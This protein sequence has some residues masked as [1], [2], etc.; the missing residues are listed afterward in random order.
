MGFQLAYRRLHGANP[1]T[2]ESCAMKH[3]FHGRTET[4]RSSTKQ[5]SSMCDAFLDDKATA[6]VKRQLLQ[7]AC[8]RHVELAGGARTAGADDNLGCDRHLRALKCLADEKGLPTPGIFNDPVFSRT[9]T[10]L[11]STSN[12]TSPIFDIFGFGAVASNGYG[13]GYMTAPSSIPM[14]ITSFK[15]GQKDPKKTGSAALATQI[16]KSFD[17]FKGVF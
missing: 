6:E 14:N 3:W 15:S 2:Y 1:P 10:W 12:V 17:D 7:A 9:S 5:S 8:K 13:V 4:I 16:F 11:L